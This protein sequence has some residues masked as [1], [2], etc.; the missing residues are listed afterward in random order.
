MTE[1][2][3]SPSKPFYRFGDIILLPKIETESWI[4]FIC[5]SFRETGK[6]ITEEESEMIADLMQ[7]HPWYVQQLSHY[8]WNLTRKSAPKLI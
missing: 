4:T 5:K 6:I 8:T 3:N 2:F 1:I 7:C